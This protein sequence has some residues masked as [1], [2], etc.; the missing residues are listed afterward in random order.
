[1]LPDFRGSGA[2]AIRLDY[3]NE[4]SLILGALG[5]EQSVCIII[6]NAPWF[7]GFWEWSNQIGTIH[8]VTSVI[9]C[10]LSVKFYLRWSRMGKISLSHQMNALGKQGLFRV[11]QTYCGKGAFIMILRKQNL[12][13]FFSSTQRIWLIQ[14]VL[15]HM[16]SI[17]SG[18]TLCKYLG[19]YC[20][21]LR[22]SFSIGTLLRKVY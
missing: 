5:V 18:T 2:G 12:L 16:W 1:M 9:Q 17:L 21:C 19:I 3:N 4:C 13:P 11:V 6:M 15:D 7:Q 8:P 20:T 22:Y 10:R 14:K